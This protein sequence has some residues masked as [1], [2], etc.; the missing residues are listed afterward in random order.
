MADEN[1]K[2]AKAAN[3]LCLKFYSGRALRV[4]I[5]KII[6]LKKC[7]GEKICVTVYESR[8]KFKQFNR[9]EAG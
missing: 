2:K 5:V 7:F 8:I 1:T 9:R 6:F 4:L 3:A